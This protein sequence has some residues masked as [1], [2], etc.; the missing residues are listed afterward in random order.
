MLAFTRAMGDSLSPLRIRPLRLY[1]GG[2]AISVMGTWMQAT[3]QS[4]VVWKLG[5]ST[6]MLGVMALLSTRSFQ[7]SPFCCWDPGQASGQTVS[8]DGSS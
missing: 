7:R 8:I 4:W 2:Q 5:H 3:A 6:T 1:L